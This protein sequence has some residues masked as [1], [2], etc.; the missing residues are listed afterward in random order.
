MDKNIKRLIENIGKDIGKLENSYIT[1]R[2]RT[3]FLE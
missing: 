3:V 2:N 1:D